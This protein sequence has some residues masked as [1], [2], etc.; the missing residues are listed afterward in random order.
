MGNH[1]KCRKA[2]FWLEE[3][4]LFCKFIKGY[5]KKEFREEFLEEY[6]I[7]I[8]ELSAGSYFPLLIDLRK[9]TEKEAFAVIKSIANNPE[10]KSAIL[11]KAFVVNSFF[12]QFTL[13]VLRRIH[14]PIIPNK[15]FTS[16][17]NAIAYSLETNH[18]FNASY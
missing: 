12:V 7:A 4:I 9:L 18:L 8:T 2:K 16:Y 1:I 15:I 5:C 17:N 3:G 13:L 10:L 14:D 6:I 11:S